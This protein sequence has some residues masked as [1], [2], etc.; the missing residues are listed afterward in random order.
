[1]A[2]KIESNLQYQQEYSFK[3]DILLAYKN[4]LIFEELIS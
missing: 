3:A 2:S 1:M 4:L